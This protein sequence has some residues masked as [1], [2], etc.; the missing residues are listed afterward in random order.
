MRICQHR[1]K[2]AEQLIILAVFLLLCLFVFLVVGFH[3][4]QAQYR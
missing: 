3:L 4:L 2:T 1:K